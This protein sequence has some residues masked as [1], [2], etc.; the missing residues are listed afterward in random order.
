MFR[1]SDEPSLARI[2]CLAGGDSERLND[3]GR[4][5]P[6][7]TDE[8]DTLDFALDDDSGGGTGLGA[9]FNVCLGLEGTVDAEGRED[10]GVGAGFLALLV[11]GAVD[12]VGVFR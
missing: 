10:E 4:F 1:T 3:L 11:A 7:D 5:F 2:F 12:E 8:E 9:D 6:A